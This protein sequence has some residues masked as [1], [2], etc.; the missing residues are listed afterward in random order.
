MGAMTRAIDPEFVGIVT[1]AVD[2]DDVAFGRI[3]TAHHDDMRRL[4]TY[5]AGDESLAEDAVQVAWSVVWRKLGSLRDPAHLRPWLMRIAVNESKRLLAKGKRR[6]DVE[7]AAFAG[8][9]RGGLDPGS[10][11]ERLDMVAA[12]GRLQPDDRALLAMRYVMG[13]DA[14]E[15]SVVTGMSP[16][17]IR[18]RLKRALDQLRED[19]E[20]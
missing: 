4:C 2:G 10:G 11:V 16:S 1:A 7:A 12:M 9:A 17:A 5:V 15:L 13:F 20:R 14:T 8:P 18:Q 19:L 6:S 3:V